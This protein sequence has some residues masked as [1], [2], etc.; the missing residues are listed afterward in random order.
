M[1]SV[2]TWV[3]HEGIMPSGI[4]KER[5][6]LYDYTHM[7]NTQKQI[8]DKKQNKQ[9]NQTKQK[10]TYR[11]Q[12]QSSGYQRGRGGVG[13]GQKALKGV[14]CMAMGGNYISGEHT[15]EYIHKSKNILLY[16]LNYRIL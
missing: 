11:C 4:N 1:P 12:E 7:Y 15:L 6:I 5:K 3:D 8:P 14:N 13:G 2:T 10:Q 9:P 16:T